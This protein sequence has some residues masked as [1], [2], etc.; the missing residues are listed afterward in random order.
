MRVIKG[1]ASWCRPGADL[2][3]PPVTCPIRGVYARASFAVSIYVF[4]ESVENCMFLYVILFCL[5]LMFCVYTM[6]DKTRKKIEKKVGW[7]WILAYLECD[8][9]VREMYQS[10]CASFPQE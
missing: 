8:A 6:Q 3:S 7:E 9:E 1:N 4:F 10:K 5:V 2:M